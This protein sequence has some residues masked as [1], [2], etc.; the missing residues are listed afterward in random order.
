M[1]KSEDQLWNELAPQLRKALGMDEITQEMA[2]EVLEE[3]EETP[4]TEKT[5]RAIV[6]A[7]TRE[8]EEMSKG[9]GAGLLRRLFPGDGPALAVPALHRN[10]GPDD[11]EVDDLVEMLREEALSESEEDDEGMDQIPDSEG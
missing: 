7:V 8:D 11:E 6:S 3:G 2:K 1:S 10:E 4:L 9:V 5:I